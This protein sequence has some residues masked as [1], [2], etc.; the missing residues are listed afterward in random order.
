MRT[1]RLHPVFGLV[2]VVPIL[3]CCLLPSRASAQ[4]EAQVESPT[5]VSPEEPVDL[6][7]AENSIAGEFTPSK[8]FDIAKT[9]WGSLNVSMYGLFRY[10]NQ[11]PTNST[12]V[13][14]LGRVQPV[15]ARNDLNWHRT[16]I[17]FS[18]FALDPRLIYVV[19]VWSL[20]TTQQTLAFGNL[21]FKFSDRL[22]LGAGMGPNLTN[23]SMQGSHPFWAS[24]D[25]LMAEEFFRGGFASG[26]WIKG[27][28]VPRFFYTLSVNTNLSQLGITAANDARDL[29]YSGSVWWEPTTGE[30]GQRGGFA[31]FEEHQSFAT[32]FGMSGG[33]VR[34]DRANEIGNSPNATQIRL[35]DG[36]FA[37]GTGALA[38]GVTVQKLNYDELAIDAGGKLR[39]LTIQA[40]YFFRVLSHFLA[41]GPV[42][43]SSIFDHGFYV[44]CMYMFVPKY[45]GLYAASS[46]VFDQF[47]RFPFEAVVGASAFPFASRSFRLNLHTIYVQKSP[48]GSNFGFYTAGETGWI[49]SVNADV[50]L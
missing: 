29:A 36:L 8:G 28:L 12:Y 31:D 25:R 22:T 6:S 39:G 1:S 7:P 48:A 2:S 44:E 35:S 42:P 24:S 40:E 9:K 23:R 4:D 20:P 27:Q 34:E 45:L 26:A 18:G 33:H 41:D 3:V 15:S 38:D 17:W 19:T 30:F 16:M 14:H 47:R 37:F 21:Q 50:L 46:V 13:D 49:V 11:L 10:L 43:E 5:D 32:R